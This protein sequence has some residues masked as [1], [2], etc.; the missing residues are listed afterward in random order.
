TGAV[1]LAG[2]PVGAEAAT[3]TI[4][5]RILET[6]LAAGGK[7]VLGKA[8]AKEVKQRIDG[9]NTYAQSFQHGRVWWG[10][11]VGKVDLPDVARVR[12]DGAQNF[13][14][15][16]GVRDLWRSDDLDDCTAL[17]ERIVRDLG[18]RTVIAFNGGSD[19]KIRSVDRYAFPISN[20]GTKLEFYQGYV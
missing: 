3:P 7:P 9:H 2:W 12:L 18:V 5:G 13:R 16:V 14:P 19:P 15:L 6:Y 1:G 4:K 20:S 8:E 17:D 10:S 11:K